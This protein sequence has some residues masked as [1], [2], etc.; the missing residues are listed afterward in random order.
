MD[1]RAEIDG[2]PVGQVAE[3]GLV[4]VLDTPKESYVVAHGIPEVFAYR[5]PGGWVRRRRL[6]GEAGE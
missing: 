1:A 4:A 3:S 5:R 2:L 6:P